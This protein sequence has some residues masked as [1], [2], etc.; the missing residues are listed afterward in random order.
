MTGQPNE[1]RG[2]LKSSSVAEGVLDLMSYPANSVANG[3]EDAAAVD[4]VELRIGQL[5]TSSSSVY[6]AF[7]GAVVPGA[8][9][10]TVVGVT[11]R[12]EVEVW[13]VVVP[14]AELLAGPELLIAVRLLLLP[15]GP[16]SISAPAITTAAI[17]AA[18]VPVPIPVLRL[19]PARFSGLLLLKPA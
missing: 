17:I 13:P 15:H 10:V 11:P 2:W 4:R 7:A 5:D 14:G 6:R 9:G 1:R 3:A 18:M 19:R 12:E 16:N 8:A